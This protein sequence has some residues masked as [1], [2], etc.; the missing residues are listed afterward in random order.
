MEN[1]EIIRKVL[2]GY[3]LRTF[4]VPDPAIP[5]N[6]PQ[7]SETYDLPHVVIKGKHF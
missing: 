3:S 6:T 1:E 2:G 5:S 4:M 7:H